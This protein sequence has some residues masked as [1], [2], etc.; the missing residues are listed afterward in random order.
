VAAVSLETAPATAAPGLGT[1]SGAAAPGRG[2]AAAT[3][4]ATAP[5]TSEVVLVGLALLLC[6]TLAAALFMPAEEDA[7][8]YYRYAL[9]WVRGKGL[10]FNPGDAVEGYSSPLWMALVAL[11]AR[12]GCR[13]PLAVPLLGIGCGAAAVEAT[14][15]LARRV[16]L[17]RFGRL[18]SVFGLALAYPFLLWSR[19]GLETPL[20]SLLLVLA[21]NLYLAAE[22]PPPADPGLRRGRRLAGGILL[23]LV[24]LARP[25]GVLLIAVVV[26]DRLADRRDWKGAV[27]YLAPAVAGYGA[28]LL[29]RL[30]A[31][32]TLVPNTSVKLYPLLLRRSTRQMLGYVIL[33]G[34]LPPL[35]PAWALLGGRLR[36]LERR[37]LVFLVSMVAMLSLL[38]QVLSGGDYRTDFRFMVPTLPILLVAIWLA[39]ER[40]EIE[41]W[42]VR[43]PFASLPARL[44]LLAL[45]V[46]GPLELVVLH[47]P[48]SRELPRL[49]EKW[50]DPYAAETADWRV[51][52]SRWVGEHVPDGSV[53]AFGQMGKVP[54][55]ATATGRDIIFLDT[56]G[57]LDRQVARIYRLDHKLAALGR[58]LAAGRS[59][60]EAVERGRRARNARFAE[61]LLARR[62]DFIIVEVYLTNYDTMLALMSRP[63]FAAR[64]R[65]VAQ[66][67]PLLR[68]PLP[69]RI[70]AL[71]RTLP[72]RG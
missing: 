51:A 68:G 19:S 27:R 12:L 66:I 3:A 55:Y 36:G 46:G 1:R 67:P 53:V 6:A 26:V 30:G 5:A 69:V 17:D 32:G 70:Y 50:I 13:L 14:Y 22:Y 40:L 63:P 11:L 49:S 33:L 57:L 10:A 29:W 61:L 31:L 64:Y 72:R 71:R 37:R 58:E 35:L 48:A 60:A 44:F 47:L 59:F 20:Y 41:R 18:A 7:F 39:A 15:R 4:A 54:Y 28:Y 21:A 9:N 16:G 65:E 2:Q 25:E 56:L 43:R 45:I 34:A 24:S 62:P 38:F 23:A 8:I 52:I 42:S